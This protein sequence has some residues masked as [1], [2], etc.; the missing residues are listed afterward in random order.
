MGKEEPKMTLNYEEA[1]KKYRELPK[2]VLGQDELVLLL[3]G[4]LDKPVNGRTVLMK[5]LFLLYEELKNKVHVASP[6][7]YPWKYGPYSSELLLVVELLE[8]YGYISVKNRRT[9]TATK[10][11]LTGKGRKVAE[12]VIE[13]LAR[14]LGEDY[15]KKLRQLRV[16]WDQLG[17]H[18]ILNYVYKRY[19]EYREKSLLKG[20][21]RPVDWGVSEA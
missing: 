9:A 17:H 15:V 8:H 18:G 19:P 21:Y 6:R 3:L 14:M 1:L 11:M 16:G 13:R 5:E 7:F 4:L 20:K 12:A 10:Y 2:P